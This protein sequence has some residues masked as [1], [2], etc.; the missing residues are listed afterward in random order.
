MVNLAFMG[1][2]LNNSDD[3]KPSVARARAPNVTVSIVTLLN[4]QEARVLTRVDLCDRP[5][6]FVGI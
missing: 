5:E 1:H 4:L 3:H 2:W 6:T